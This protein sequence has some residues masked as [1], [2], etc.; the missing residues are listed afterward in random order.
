[1][2][3][4]K[5]IKKTISNLLVEDFANSQKYFEAASLPISKSKEAN[6]LEAKA[7]KEL[8]QIKSKYID[9]LMALFIVAID[10]SGDR[11]LEVF[12][13][14]GLSVNRMLKIVKEEIGVK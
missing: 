6:K 5:E 13:G 7:A 3:L 11:L 9:K 1:M 4:K 14:E 2:N 12:L 10:K 8:E